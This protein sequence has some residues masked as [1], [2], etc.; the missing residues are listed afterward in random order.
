MSNVGGHLADPLLVK[1]AF[2]EIEHSR[3]FA[4]NDRLLEFL[5]FVVQ[6]TLEGHLEHLK[7]SVIGVEVYRRDPDY[8]PKSDPIV[9]TE[10][11]RLRKKLAEYYE[12][13]GST[14]CIVIVLPVGGYVAQF[15]VRKNGEPDCLPDNFETVASDLLVLSPTLPSA[16]PGRPVARSKRWL[17]LAALGS[18]SVLLVSIAVWKWSH[19]SNSSEIFVSFPVTFNDGANPI[20]ASA[21]SPDGRSLVYSDTTGLFQRSLKTGIVRPL[22]LPPALRVQHLA[23]SA[24]SN[25][26]LVSAYDTQEN[27]DQVW[28]LDPAV[29]R[30]QKLLSRSMSASFSLDGQHLLF[31]NEDRSHIEI[32]SADGSGR[33]SFLSASDNWLFAA[34][35]WSPDGRRILYIQQRPEPEAPPVFS[36]SVETRLKRQYLAR[37]VSDGRL[38][39]SESPFSFDSLCPLRDGR[40]LMLW[41]YH[42]PGSKGPFGVWTARLDEK[43]GAVVGDPKLTIS[44]SNRF[45][46]SLS[47]TADGG[48]VSGLVEGG[49]ADVYIAMEQSVPLG[50]A[51]RLTFDLRNDFP[52]AWTP[53]GRAV[54]FESERSGSYHLYRQNLDGKVAE[55]LTDQ[56]GNQV[57]AAVSPDGKWLLFVQIEPGNRPDLDRLFR[58][59]LAGGTRSKV[60]LHHSFDEFRCPLTGKTC[61]IRETI[62]HQFYRFSALDPITGQG[63][64]LAEVPWMPSIFGD[65]T[66]A[67]DGSAVALPNH[68]EDAPEILVVP[69]GSSAPS[70]TVKVRAQGQLWGIHAAPKQQ[71]WYGEIRSEGKHNL[72]LINRDGKVTVL[73]ECDYNTWAYPSPDGS[74]LAFVDY[75]L[76]R[77]VWI[78]RRNR[79]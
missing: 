47:T 70:W 56:A 32:A 63:S 6:N 51:K 48:T 74:K 46:T 77:N 4:K 24:D 75:T 30:A 72:S 64:V 12:Q 43:T 61:V 35:V 42:L 22:E 16:E 66:I 23:W 41:P 55:I 37:N 49:Q 9:R 34:A 60:P 14:A 68:K 38:V 69:L 19:E 62:G 65:W 18:L 31:L 79:P 36:R 39:A 67:S 54:I 50:A 44:T 53:D 25:M 71:A 7:E 15:E 27:D 3:T 2:Q 17:W 28:K 29:R 1:T 45:I 59:P 26:L 5:R 73:R 20:A 10:A 8:S 40:M 57:T 76:D 11:R 52:D 78:W 13:E 21:I 58:V 33:R